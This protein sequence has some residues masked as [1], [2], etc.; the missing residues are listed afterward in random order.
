MVWLVRENRA[1][2]AG[3]RDHR[4]DADEETI[5]LLGNEHP[6]FRLTI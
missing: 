4:L 3:E 5:A 1:R 2:R 6:K